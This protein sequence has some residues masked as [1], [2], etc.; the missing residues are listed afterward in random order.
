MIRG[1][2]SF[3]AALQLVITSESD[4]EVALPGDHF[5]RSGGFYESSLAIQVNG[6]RRA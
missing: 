6:S 2:T 1:F 3:A 5:A 4:G